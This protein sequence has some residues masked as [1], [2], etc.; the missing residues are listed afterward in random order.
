[1]LPGFRLIAATFLCGFV[2]VFAG[3]RLATSIH[4]MHAAFPV[5]AAHAAP[6]PTTGAP[7]WPS[8]PAAAPMLYDLRFV[9]SATAPMT[10]SLRPQYID[11][12]APVAIPVVIE[13]MAREP[14]APVQPTEPQSPSA[15]QTAPEA[16][17]Q[18]EAPASQPATVAAID[19][20][21]TAPAE[22]ATV[23][24]A[25]AQQAGTSATEAAEAPKADAAAN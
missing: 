4:S 18:P 23:E 7:D 8:V 2:L 20:Q 10:V 25:A 12:L 9:A 15:S 24:P 6:A 14:A 19:P 11:R 17:A 21:S 16:A 1:M 3:L 13:E 22:T 5:M